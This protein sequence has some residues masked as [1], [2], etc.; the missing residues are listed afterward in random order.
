MT[1]VSISSKEE[2]ALVWKKLSVPC[3]LLLPAAE[4]VEG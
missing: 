1:S 4:G 2:M 3:S